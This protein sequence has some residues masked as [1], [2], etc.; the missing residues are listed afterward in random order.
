MAYFYGMTQYRRTATICEELR[1]EGD[2]PED[3]VYPAAKWIGDLIPEVMASMAPA[4]HQAFLWLRECAGRIAAQ[5]HAIRWTSPIGM[6]V[7][8]C[9]EKRRRINTANYTLYV[10]QRSE[11]AEV[12][13]STYLFC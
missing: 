10:Q 9:P 4:P 13:K 12:L 3:D 2:C 6:P 11:E 8:Q 1:D 5:G 7:A